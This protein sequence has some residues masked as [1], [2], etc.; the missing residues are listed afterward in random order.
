M[1]ALWETAVVFGAILGAF[2]L[3][4]ADQYC[5]IFSS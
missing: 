4:E 1:M 5:L 3:K 2:V